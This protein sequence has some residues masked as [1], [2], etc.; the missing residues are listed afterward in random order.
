MTPHSGRKS[1]QTAA[2]WVPL[3][4]PG[5]PMKI[6]RI[7][8]SFRDVRLVGSIVRRRCATSGSSVGRFVRDS[9]GVGARVF[10]G[11]GCGREQVAFVGELS[12]DAEFA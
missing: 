12:V 3:P 4:A 6:S 9:R 2:D 11:I 10:D 7:G 1:R 8:W 5:G